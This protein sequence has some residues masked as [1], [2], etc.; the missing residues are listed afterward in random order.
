M[1]KLLI[2]VA[3]S[4]SIIL[5]AQPN[6]SKKKETITLTQAIQ[7]ASDSS[8]AAFKTK[9][10]YLSGYWQYR[11]FKAERLPSMS[12]DLTPLS[13]NQN[14]IK[15]YDYIN[16]I[17]TYKSQQSLNSSANLSIKQNVDLTGGTF[18]IDTELAYLR[19]FG[20]TQYEQYTSVP[21]R[22]GYSQSLFGYNRFKWEKK[23]EP[24][25]YEKVKK[26]LLYNM[27]GIAE[28]TSDYFFNLAAYQTLYSLAKQNVA[29]SDTLY[30]IG[31]ERY[32]I[33]TISQSELL[34]LKLDLINAQNNIGNAEL[35]L[36]KSTFNL[37][38]FLHFDNHVNIYLNVPESTLNVFINAEEAL[39]LAKENNPTYLEQKENMLTAQQNLDQAIKASRF[40][41][42]LSASVGFNQVANDFGDAYRKPL[43]QD[44]VSLGLNVPIVDWGVRRGKVNIAKR[45]LEATNISAMQAEQTFEQDILN[46]VSEYNLRHSQIGMAKEAKDIANQAFE[47]T[48]QLFFIGKT[49]VNTVNIAVSRQIEAESNYISALKN[50]WIS[51]YTIR[52]LTLFDF[53]ERK[54]ISIKFEEIHG[55]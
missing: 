13:Y 3:C 24:L 10:L 27:E 45:N 36:K 21:V 31:V 19:N 30:K 2:I 1:K 29:N 50:Y 47:K 49:D 7:I 39:R 34:T 8:L 37:A 9:N 51:Y 4:F 14:F 26:E 22:I 54:S 12:V 53:V 25:K 38:A 16:N 15:R 20:L 44:V 46:A 42:S 55:Y 28:Q 11:T 6:T 17:D 5:F 35:N 23:I 41:A 48:K 18:F 43:Q 40:S 52:K 32:K 33:G